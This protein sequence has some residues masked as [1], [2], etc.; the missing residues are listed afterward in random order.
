[1]K[2]SR[3]QLYHQLHMTYLRCLACCYYCP[4]IWLAFAQFE[5]K[6]DWKRAV[7]VLQCAMKAIPESIILRLA[8]CDFYEEHDQLTYAEEE[9]E[10]IVSTVNEPVGWIEY[11]R[12]TRR[13]KGVQAYRDLFLRAKECC[14]KPEV[15]VTAGKR[16]FIG[17]NEQL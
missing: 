13:Q 8:C 10:K 6:Y 5:A 4:D 2:L 15:F 9:Y 14:K 7:N 1:M 11:M 3:E 17:N 12:Y 16:S